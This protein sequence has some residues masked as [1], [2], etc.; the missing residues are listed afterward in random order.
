MNFVLIG[1]RSFSTGASVEKTE[2]RWFTSAGRGFQLVLKPVLVSS[3][4]LGTGRDMPES[5]ANRPW[6]GL[7][8]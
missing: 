1:A 4:M 5:A 7:H 3:A 2:T 8:C 6:L